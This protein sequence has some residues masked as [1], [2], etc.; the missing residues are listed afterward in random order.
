M[1]SQY[2]DN[3]SA[4]RTPSDFL[5]H[6]NWS[7]GDKWTAENTNFIFRYDL[8]LTLGRLQIMRE[9]REIRTRFR[10]S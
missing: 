8:A 3:L 10:V 6:I 7:T 5:R 1:I 9:C 2:V 4:I